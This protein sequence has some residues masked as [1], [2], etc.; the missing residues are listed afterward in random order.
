[1]PRVPFYKEMDQLWP[2]GPKYLPREGVFPLSSDSAWLGAFV[3]LTGVRRVCDLGCGGGVLG[4]QLLGRKPELAVS[5]LDILPEA[6][7]AAAANAALN[8]FSM[9]VVCGDLRDWRRFFGPGSFD[10]VVSNPPYHSADGPSAAGSRGVA[11]QESCT[12][13]E[14]CEA[15]SGLLK[16]RGRFCLVYPPQRL[17]E[18]LIAMASAELEPKRLQFVQKNG[19][20]APCAALLE[21]IRGGGKGLAVLPPLLTEEEA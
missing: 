5:A 18:L 6:A 12:P 14:L 21:G 9:S 15:A 10:L 2:G 7:A 3:R 11:R 20:T 8:G 13:A 4:L 19:K 1:M 16:Q 17:P